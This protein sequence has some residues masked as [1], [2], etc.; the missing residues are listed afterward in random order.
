[1]PVRSVIIIC[2]S[3]LIVGIE[4]RGDLFV[5]WT[6][7]WTLS[8]HSEW[9]VID[10]CLGIVWGD[11]DEKKILSYHYRT[12]LNISNVCILVVQIRSIVVCESFAKSTNIACTL[13][14]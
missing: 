1:M 2:L 14:H 11:K 12:T 7:L 13:G 5:D 3:G 8:E 4:T 6:D 9:I 10:C